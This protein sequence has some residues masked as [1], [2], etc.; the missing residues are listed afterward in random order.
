MP[1]VFISHSTEDRAF[2]EREIVAPLKREG[3]YPFY[4]RESINT[5]DLWE[6]KIHENLKSCDWFLVVITINAAKSS[7]V[8]TEVSSAFQYRKRVIPVL[9]DETNMDDVHIGLLSIQ[10]VD[11][12]QDMQE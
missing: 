7:W 1:K 10:H 12:R 9:C 4:A 8:Y 11:F 6:R 3:I 2:V 5:G